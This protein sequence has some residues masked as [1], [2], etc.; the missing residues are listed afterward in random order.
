MQFVMCCGKKSPKN[1]RDI[2]YS[3]TK[4]PEELSENNFRKH[5]KHQTLTTESVR[6]SN[7]EMPAHQTKRAA[8][9]KEVKIEQTSTSE[10]L[11]KSD[12]E[13]NLGTPLWMVAYPH[14]NR[15]NRG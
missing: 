12:N 5:T 3:T 11:E 14:P 9:K 10:D 15:H 13:T 1:Y 6:T 4:S 2:P 8:G 7:S